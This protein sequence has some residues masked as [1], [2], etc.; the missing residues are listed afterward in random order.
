M[1]SKSDV[2][3]TDRLVLRRA[4]EEDLDA[5]HAIFGDEVAMRYWSS[6]PHRDLETSREW[7]RSMIEA[8]PRESDDF[9]VTLDGKTIGKMGAYQ[10][11]EFGFLLAREHWGKGLASEAL[12]AFLD[13]RRNVAPGSYLNADVDPRNSG[14]LRLLKRHG[15]VETGRAE[16]TWTINGEVCD[17]IYL[18]LEL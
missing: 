13:H 18:A 2:I 11:P 10:L 6:P 5:F 7:L 17:S 16:G 12:A 4:L 9:V 15:F 8:G 14:S 3:R 1:L